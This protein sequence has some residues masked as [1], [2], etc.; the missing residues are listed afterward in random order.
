MLL[1][2]KSGGGNGGHDTMAIEE[3][4]ETALRNRNDVQATNRWRIIIIIHNN[5]PIA[6]NVPEQNWQNDDDERRRFSYFYY[7]ESGRFVL[8]GRLVGWLAINLW[9]L[10]S[11]S[12]CWVCVRVWVDVGGA[13]VWRLFSAHQAPNSCC[14]SINIALFVR[15]FLRFVSFRFFLFGL[16]RSS[17]EIRVNRLG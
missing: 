15:F 1:S 9:M 10:V 6:G 11:A 5:V 8:G 14:I 3:K 12:E 17:T 4:M 7:I 16:L 13:W 2:R